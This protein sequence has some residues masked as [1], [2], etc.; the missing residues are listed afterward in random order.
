MNYLCNYLNYGD[1][2][3]KKFTKGLFDLDGTITDPAEGII[4]SY[5]F[6]LNKLGL[7]ELDPSIISSYIGASLHLYFAEKHNLSDKSLEDGIKYYREYFVV[8]GLYENK[9]YAGF[10]ILIKTLFESGIN[11][12]LVTSK[13]TVY[14]KEILHHFK[15]EQYF[16]GVYGSELT[17]Q[18]TSKVDLLAEAISKEK[19]N[20]D[21]T[22][23]I[24]DRNLDVFGAKANNIS[25]A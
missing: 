18:N 3:I 22:I 1:C 20:I 5:L 17:I 14:A 9:L 11:I 6:A 7:N 24:G 4:N 2:T 10:D 21:N 19:L 12:Y 8:K 16:K 23:M 13:P 25:S 15:L